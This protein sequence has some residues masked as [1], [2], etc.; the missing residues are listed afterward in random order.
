MSV[1]KMAAYRLGKAIS[2]GLWNHVPYGKVRQ[3]LLRREVVTKEDVIT[4][5]D[6][7]L[8]W[9]SKLPYEERIMAQRIIRRSLGSVIKKEE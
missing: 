2:H 9:L 1:I 8:V 3:W 5:L 6:L 7:V 4:E